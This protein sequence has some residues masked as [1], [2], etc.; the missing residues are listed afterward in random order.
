MVRAVAPKNVN[1]STG[2]LTHVDTWTTQEVVALAGDLAV[3]EVSGEQM[4]TLARMVIPVDA[5]DF[6]EIDGWQRVTND[7]GPVRYTCGVGF[8]VDVYDVDDGLSTSNP[9]RVWLRV[10]SLD[11]QNVD[12]SIV[13]HLPLTLSG[14]T[15]TV[16]ATWP[17]GHRA[18]VC[19]RADAHSTQAELANGGGDKITVDDYGVLTVTR[20]KPYVEDPRWANFE[21]RIAALEQPTPPKGA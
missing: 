3:G 14:V 4:R 6:L 16:P 12:R 11:G 1:Y 13:H 15:W 20:W 18:V 19:F 17:A 2:P 10:S 5:G 8:W 21:E 7:I 9:A